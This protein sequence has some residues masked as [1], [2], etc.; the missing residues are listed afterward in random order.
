MT[1]GERLTRLADLERLLGVS[2]PPRCYV[3]YLPTAKE[4]TI[5]DDDLSPATRRAP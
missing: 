1:R 2:A 5:M 4:P 3:R